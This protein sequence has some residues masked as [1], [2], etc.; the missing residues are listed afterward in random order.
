MVVFGQKDSLSE[1]ADQL[2]NDCC[3][4]IP[5]VF[6]GGQNALDKFL[7]DNLQYP[8]SSKTAGIE[9]EVIAYFIID[10]LGKVTEISIILGLSAEINN[11]VIR[12]LSLMPTWIPGTCPD[13]KKKV[14]TGFTF[15]IIFKIDDGTNE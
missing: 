10:T 5:P 9:G 13:R 1:T 14:K 11:E 4:E 12:V 8:D 6:P 15:P 2:I 7:S 3:Y